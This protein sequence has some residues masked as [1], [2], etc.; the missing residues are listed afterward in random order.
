M[1]FGNFGD[2]RVLHW[3]CHVSLGCDES[4]KRP[5][6]VM[7]QVGIVHKRKWY[8]FI[9]LRA[10]KVADVFFETKALEGNCELCSPDQHWVIKKG[11]GLIWSTL[12]PL[13]STSL[14]KDDTNIIGTICSCQ[15]SKIWSVTEKMGCRGWVPVQIPNNSKDALRLHAWQQWLSF[16][17]VKL[18]GILLGSTKPQSI[19]NPDQVFNFQP[20]PMDKDQ[21]IGAQTMAL[22]NLGATFQRYAVIERD[23][24]T[25]E[26][27][28][29]ILSQ[30][31]S[32]PEIVLDKIFYR[33]KQPINYG[34]VVPDITGGFVVWNTS[35]L[36]ISERLKMIQLSSRLTNQHDQLQLDPSIINEACQYAA[37]NG[38][39]SYLLVMPPWNNQSK[40]VDQSA[41]KLGDV[42]DF[43]S[44]PDICLKIFRQMWTPQIFSRCWSD[45]EPNLSSVM[46]DKRAVMLP[47]PARVILNPNLELVSTLKWYS[48]SM[49]YQT[50]NGDA[51]CLYLGLESRYP[52]KYHGSYRAY[53]LQ[54]VALASALDAHFQ[55]PFPTTKE[56][57]VLIR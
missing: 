28:S 13:Y 34:Q 31:K 9:R 43:S 20:L 21:W 40:V 44:Y 48:T 41:T 23:S 54:G 38:D 51:V 15:W 24:S 10:S 17:P 32:Q 56:V 1:F 53:R 8:E 4:V 11:N 26:W 45:T 42:L 29:T 22:F 3:S 7:K 30:P 50:S 25:S 39:L 16:D 27:H 19:A 2:M 6:D 5:S 12:E 36:A 18:K 55:C 35:N 33:N 37:V 14:I 49:H 46:L 47:Q 52:D 57:M